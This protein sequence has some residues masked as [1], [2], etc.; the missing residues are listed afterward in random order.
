MGD[1]ILF[2]HCEEQINFYLINQQKVIYV[3]KCVYNEYCKVNTEI[4]IK[5]NFDVSEF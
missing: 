3:Y 2:V 4:V 1:R 5:R